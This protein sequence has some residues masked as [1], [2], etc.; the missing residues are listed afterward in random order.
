MAAVRADAEAPMTKR[1]IDRRGNREAEHGPGDAVPAEGGAVDHA[2]LGLGSP[3]GYSYIYLRGI[4]QT[5]MNVTL[6]GV[7]LNEPEDSAFYFANFGDFA[8]ALESLQ[9]QRGVGTSTVGAASFAGSINFASI[10]LKDKAAADVRLGSGSFGTNR[11]SAAVA[12][13]QAR[14]RHQALWPGRI[15]GLRT[16]SGTT[17]ARRSAACISARR[18]TPPASFFKVFGF[19]GAGSIPARVPRRR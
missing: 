15:P 10:D 9:V 5:R 19:R 6:D 7:P 8:N 4:P 3:T 18:A 13:G 1:D 12:L 16:G 11:V 14:R 17:R 2:V